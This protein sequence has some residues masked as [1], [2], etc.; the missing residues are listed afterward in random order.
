MVRPARNRRKQ[1]TSQPIAGVAEVC[2]TRSLLCATM[3]D[4]PV[5]VSDAPT[6]DVT[7][8]ATVK[9]SSDEFSSIG[10]DVTTFEMIDGTTEDYAAITCEM[11]VSESPTDPVEGPG[12]MGIDF[13]ADEA[14]LVE[15]GAEIYQEYT[16]EGL[17]TDWNP[18]WGYRFLSVEST[19]A[20][21]ATISDE[22]VQEF[23]DS[24]ILAEPIDLKILESIELPMVMDLLPEGETL[25]ATLNPDEFIVTCFASDMPGDTFVDVTAE[26]GDSKE[27]LPNDTMFGDAED[28]NVYPEFIYTMVMRSNVPDGDV[29]KTDVVEEA[30]EVE[31]TG[32]G[33][34]VWPTLL[35]EGSEELPEDQFYLA[36][37]SAPGI[38]DQ[39]ADDVVE[40]EVEFS[41]SLE[42]SPV[43][44]FGTT[45]ADGETELPVETTVITDDGS[46]P[47]DEIV[48]DD[49]L[50]MVAD[51]IEDTDVI[52]QSMAGGAVSEESESAPTEAPVSRP[53]HHHG[54]FS[55]T[56]MFDQSSDP[57]DSIGTMF[58]RPTDG[59]PGDNRVSKT[60]ANSTPRSAVR[61]RPVVAQ[62][63]APGLVSR[64]LTPLL[65]TD[66]QQTSE[67]STDDSESDVTTSGSQPTANDSE[68]SNSHASASTANPPHRNR[69]IDLFMSQFHNEFY[70]S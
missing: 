10:E 4:A 44:Y 3:L 59:Q 32:E 53:Q 49:D 26:P 48:P 68:T 12:V 25:D 7:A 60:V 17:P 23:G 5:E 2:E 34:E 24:E 66:D 39:S 9:V 41:G 58:A 29:E 31:L 57:S 61:L 35:P 6:E 30:V 27:I 37:S 63:S 38:L 45:A 65:S 33:E 64:N 67:T 47:D 70:A 40:T 16:E 55:S 54:P 43:L 36:Y 14:V 50:V 69:S 46:V 19:T 15:E 20:D 56:G 62:R 18:A 22:M 13:I 8:D 52:F 28:P 51:E 11:F 42:D 21:E 1:F